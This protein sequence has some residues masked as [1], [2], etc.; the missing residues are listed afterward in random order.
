MNRSFF[1][2]LALSVASITVGYAI[3]YSYLWTY[4]TAS[5]A[6]R[7]GIFSTTDWYLY[8]SGNVLVVA[9][10]G[11]WWWLLWQGDGLQ[12]LNA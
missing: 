1:R 10:V 9:G 7:E 3:V 8:L 6:V 4:R 12:T 2:E 11:W 5:V